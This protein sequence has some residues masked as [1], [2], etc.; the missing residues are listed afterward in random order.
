MTLEYAK[1]EHFRHFCV[2][3]SFFSF[4]Y[5]ELEPILV[6]HNIDIGLKTCDGVVP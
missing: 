5:S 1:G 3:F 2:R 6:R 4:K